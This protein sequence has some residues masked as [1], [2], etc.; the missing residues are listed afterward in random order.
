MSNAILYFL[1]DVLAK[2]AYLE[3]PSIVL[4]CEHM[5]NI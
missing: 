3:P 4:Q 5:V 1:K 2:A